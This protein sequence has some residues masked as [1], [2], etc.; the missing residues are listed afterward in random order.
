MAENA[1]RSRRQQHSVDR[2]NGRLKFYF[3]VL[4]GLSGLILTISSAQESLPVVVVFFVLLGYVFVDY[5]QLIALPAAMAYIAMAG[6]ALYSVSSFTDFQRPG[7][8]QIESVILLL[9]LVQ[10]ILM[11]QRKTKR[12]FE[13]LAIF[14]LMDLVVAA[15]LNQAIYFAVLLI[16][17]GV[18][19][20]ATLVMLAAVTATSAD[21]E[22]DQPVFRLVYRRG[23]KASSEIQ[24]TPLEQPISLSDVAFRLARGA[25]L[26]LFPPVLA[27][28]AI[29]FYGLPRTVAAARSE[30]VGRAV[31]GFSEEL[32]LEQLGPLLQSSQIALRCQLS[33]QST[34]SLYSVRNGLY[35]RGKVL[36]QYQVSSQGGRNVA[37]WRALEASEVRYDLPEPYQPDQSADSQ[38]FDR[39]LVEVTCEPM[40]DNSLFAIAPYHQT[41]LDTKLRHQT[42]QWTITRAPTG[43]WSH[44]RTEYRFGTSAFYRGVQSEIIARRPQPGT[45]AE[46]SSVLKSPTASA[47]SDAYR[48][49]LLDFEVGKMPTAK[50]LAERFATARDERRKTN[51][52]IAKSLESY[53]AYAGEYRYSL[54]L[55]AKPLVDVDPIEQF[56]TVDKAGHCQYFASALTMMLRSQGIP[57]RIVAGYRT[58]ELDRLSQRFVARQLHAHAWVEALIDADDLDPSRQVFGQAPA[59]QYWLRLDPTPT[60]SRQRTERQS[61][62]QVFDLAQ[63]LWEEYV[64]EIES[65]HQD[66][67]VSGRGI[68]GGHSPL[69]QFV[70]WAIERTGD[71]PWKPLGGPNLNSRS[72]WFSWTTAVAAT[73]FLGM[74]VAGM[75]AVCRLLIRSLPS[76]RRHQSGQHLEHGRTAPTIGFL[77]QAIQQLERLG[78]R[79]EPHQTPREFACSVAA[80]IEGPIA[81]SLLE[82]MEQLT[83]IYYRLRFRGQH[84]ATELR[85]RAEQEAIGPL[86]I[87]TE[88]V[89]RV[90]DTSEAGGASE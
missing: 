16:P 81:D 26:I 8:Q 53:L 41:E 56:L 24:C 57:A 25:I 77:N 7:N 20:L 47:D 45:S 9:I 62:G 52:D 67:S 66:S 85:S 17:T 83:T 40:R 29:Y 65:S 73:A 86:A 23:V 19:G 75:I 74:V 82:P 5:L 58:T 59:S 71:L 1:N 69:D 79:R 6:V 11:L 37:T 15:V 30:N 18:V 32:H 31:V 10:V 48:D 27:I 35:L 43:R 38:P 76:L 78:V 51:Y 80:S 90:I 89:Q 50:R 21:N 36:E 87:L 2:I 4:T 88:N 34:S 68:A 84:G 44:P 61:A 12:I 46:A 13:Q 3:A 70:A 54:D 22:Q 60:A 14:C 63:N 42:E 49:A 64:V 39:V 28:A 55:S 72:S 33:S